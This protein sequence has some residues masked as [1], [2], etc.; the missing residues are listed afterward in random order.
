MA[1]FAIFG[2]QGVNMACDTQN[3]QPQHH[4]SKTRHPFGQSDTYFNLLYLNT[5]QQIE[6]YVFTS[7]K[8]AEI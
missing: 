8:F 4:F 6:S 1:I 7:A 3:L 5:A 2:K